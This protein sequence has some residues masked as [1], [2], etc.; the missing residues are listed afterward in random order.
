M[1]DLVFI[2]NESD[3]LHAFSI[4]RN[5]TFD[6]P[7]SQILPI[8]NTLSNLYLY[9]TPSLNTLFKLIINYEQLGLNLT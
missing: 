9:S 7:F 3:L 2:N 4:L 5:H 1:G 6:D 8:L